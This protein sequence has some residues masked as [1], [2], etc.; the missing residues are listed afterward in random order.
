MYNVYDS[1]AIQST[2]RH[3]QLHTYSPFRSAIP[4]G[5]LIPLPIHEIK[6][7]YAFP[8][9]FLWYGLSFRRESPK[10]IEKVASG[11]MRW[12]LSCALSFPLLEVMYIIVVVW[13]CAKYFIVLLIVI[14]VWPSN[15]MMTSCLVNLMSTF[16]LC[17]VCRTH[18][19]RTTTHTHT[20]YEKLTVCAYDCA[21]LKFMSLTIS[22]IHIP[23]PTR[24]CNNNNSEN[25]HHP[26]R[27]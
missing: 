14:C 1:V 17:C 13:R 12:L 23:T 8:F 21:R 9:N 6:R 3:P 15:E 26:Q 22:F 5:N 24:E 7:L 11:C 10:K 19:Q 2:H 25:A 27:E 4:P 20:K 16:L 18:N